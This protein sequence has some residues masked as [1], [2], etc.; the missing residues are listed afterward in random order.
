M[1]A[2]KPGL[3]LRSVVSDAEVVIVRS[4][5]ADVEITCGGQPMVAIDDAQGKTGEP[6]DEG[7]VQLGKRYVD[8]EAG[9]EVLCTKAGKGELAVGGRALNLKGAKPLPSSD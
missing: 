8:D 6:A 1:A 2:I 3:R 7:E 5:S 4:A 9:L